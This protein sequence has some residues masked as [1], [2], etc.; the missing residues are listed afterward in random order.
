[1]NKNIKEKFKQITL[2]VFA[3]TLI[4]VGYMNFSLEQDKNLA[5][6]EDKTN[7]G[8]VELVSSSNVQQEEVSDTTEIIKEDEIEVE[9]TISDKVDEISDYFTNSKIER[10][11]MYS[12]ILENYQNMIDT[13]NISNEQKAIAINEITRINNEK[14]SI[15]I[16]ENL[17]KN[18]GLEEVLILINNNMASIV[19]KAEV[20]TVEN[21][22]QI[23]NI[24]S[25]QLQIDVGNINITNKYK[26][27]L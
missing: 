11:K 10:N 7:I 25:R 3:I 13:S 17:I 23:Q 5:S 20:L 19:V 1:M 9:E 27:Q 4:G 24:A 16:A 21:I 14:N 2:T 18:K 26:K 22:A 12:E 6:R 15:M 8:D